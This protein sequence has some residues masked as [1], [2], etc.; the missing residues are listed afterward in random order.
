MGLIDILNGMQAGPRGRQQPGA[1][2]SGGGVSPLTMALIGLLAYKAFKGSGHATA[3][4]SAP[5]SQPGG[6][7]GDILGGL[8]GGRPGAAPG[9]ANLND[10]LQGGLGGLLG[11]QGGTVL[12]NGLGNLVKQFQENG[13]GRA[14]QSWVGT[15]P[16]EEIAPKDLEDAL[17]SG[18]LDA[19]AQQTGMRRGDLLSGLS[20]QLPELID[21][22]TPNGRVPTAEEASRM[23]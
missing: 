23:V 11:G 5:A 12:S 2:G 6:G 17:G 8:L 16:N 10:L 13:H 22:L 21:K 18:T 7:L 9:G 20:Q 15:G 14:A 4:P 19:L 1:S 3:A